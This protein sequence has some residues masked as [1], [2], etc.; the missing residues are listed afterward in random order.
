LNRSLRAGMIAL[1]AAALLFPN[2]AVA[3]DEGAPHDHPGRAEQLPHQ[4]DAHWP[5]PAAGNARFPIEDGSHDTGSHHITDPSL[6]EDGGGDSGTGTIDEG[7][8]TFLSSHC[9]ADEFDTTTPN[10]IVPVLAYDSRKGIQ[11]TN[12]KAK[13][14]KEIRAADRAIEES[15]STFKQHMRLACAKDGTTS[16]VRIRVMDVAIP[17]TADLNSNNYLNCNETLE[18]LK[19]RSPF[20]RHDPDRRHYWFLDSGI[21]GDRCSFGYSDALN[22]TT[23]GTKNPNNTAAGWASSDYAEWYADGVSNRSVMVTLQELHHSLGLLSDGTASGSTKAP[24]NCCGSHSRDNYDFMNGGYCRPNSQGADCSDGQEIRTTCSSPPTT[25]PDS[26]AD[27]GRDDY[28]VP[29]FTTANYVCTHYNIATDSLYYHQRAARP[30][31]CTA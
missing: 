28:W 2:L 1:G 22:N 16:Y 18:Y 4:A 10:V 24:S 31:G 9:A 12:A 23:P 29:N 6:F 5:P 13:I 7:T 19:A 8:T 27:C 11:V 26:Y 21:A 3:H 30:A 20:Y 14:R 15:H 17:G 25:F